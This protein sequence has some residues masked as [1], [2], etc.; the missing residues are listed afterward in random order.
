MQEDEFTETT[1]WL[2][3]TERILTIVGTWPKN[4]TNLRFIL[5]LVYMTIFVV[6]QWADF[7]SHIDDLQELAD[8]LC[9]TV[10]GTM[11]VIKLLVFHKN[12]VLSKM[13][14]AVN[15]DCEN[16]K[17]HFSPSEKRKYA[18]C[19]SKGKTFVKI[20]TFFVGATCVF[21][22]LKPLPI[23]VLAANRN[24]STSLVLP[25]R[26]SLSF[27]RTDAYVYAV[28]YVCQMGALLQIFLGYVGTH[29][30]L[31]TLMMHICGE[32]SVLSER[33]VN[34]KKQMEKG[35]RCE[36]QKITTRHLRLIWMA[37]EIDTAFTVVLLSQV[38]S[39]E[40]MICVA[41]FNMIV[42]SA[43]SEKTAFITFA[44]YE[45][46]ALVDLY[47][48]CFIGE[49]L[50]LES[51]RISDAVYDCAWYEMPPSQAKDLILVMA[52]S[53]KPLH[54]TAG[55][56]FVFSLEIFSEF[57]KTSMAYLSVLRAMT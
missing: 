25:F 13:I 3:N 47:V 28:L 48:Y 56:I 41:G 46:A 37:K 52:R 21:Y 30:L 16:N 32:L 36:I 2:T 5:S 43:N 53:Q 35:H 45:V 18:L 10:V 20:F 33:I 6:M 22:Y 17:L 34:M 24:G 42:Y 54:L 7:V 1:D 38:I 49:C 23:T 26:T 57:V 12:R 9:E 39:S 44:L 11:V 51:T 14:D 4:K 50:I 27:E 15:Q 8:I 29:A 31:I 19:N 40:I 55:K